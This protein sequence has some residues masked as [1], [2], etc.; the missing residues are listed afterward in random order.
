MCGTACRV[1]SATT[2]MEDY[3]LKWYRGTECAATT[4]QMTIVRIP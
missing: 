4:V 2:D 3:E 1:N